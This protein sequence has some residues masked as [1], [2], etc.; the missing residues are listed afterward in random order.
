MVMKLFILVE[1]LDEIEFYNVG[2]YPS[3]DSATVAKLEFLEFEEANT[4]YNIEECE[5]YPD[6]E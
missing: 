1:C 4:Q 6:G 2:I 3:W 5:F